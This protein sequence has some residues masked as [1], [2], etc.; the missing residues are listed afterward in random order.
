MTGVEAA[1]P[2][3]YTSSPEHEAISLIFEAKRELGQ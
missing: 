3:L 2:D 1:R